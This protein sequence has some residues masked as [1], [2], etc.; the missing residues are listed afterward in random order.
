MAVFGHK[1]RWQH[2]NVVGHDGSVKFGSDSGKQS[3]SG[4]DKRAEDVTRFRRTTMSCSG[5]LN[6]VYMLGTCAPTAFRQGGPAMAECSQ[7][8]RTARYWCQRIGALVPS[9]RVIATKSGETISTLRSLDASIQLAEFSP[10]GKWLAVAGEN[11]S[12][13]LWSTGSGEQIGSII[14]QGTPLRLRFLQRTETL[15]IATNVAISVWS[16]TT[17]AEPRS[18]PLP[19][20]TKAAD[21]SASGVAALTAD[22]SGELRLWQLDSG[23]DRVIGRHPD[24]TTVAFSNGEGVFASGGLRIDPCVV[25]RPR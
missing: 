6:R 1:T 13:T 17:A 3:V 8:R 5:Q 19:P 16:F 7:S 20:G 12:V 24:V 9:T 14:V 21:V 18:L 23:Q 2:R 11:G 10:E 25:S 4:W 22:D 15:V